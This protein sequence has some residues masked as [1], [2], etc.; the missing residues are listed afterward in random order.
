MTLNPKDGVAPGEYKV[1]VVK[2][3]TVLPVVEDDPGLHPEE[4]ARQKA[5]RLREAAK[6]KD[7]IKAVTPDK[8][9]SPARSG[10]TASIGAKGDKNLRFDLK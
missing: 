10:L 8:Y 9:L 7:A 5:I 1:T 6:S 4:N 3:A 2:Y